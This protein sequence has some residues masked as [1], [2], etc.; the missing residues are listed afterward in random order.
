MDAEKIPDDVEDLDALPIT[1]AFSTG[2]QGAE[3]C[4][5]KEGE[6]VLA[7]GCAARSA[8]SRG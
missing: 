7:L 4:D 5:L 6:T 2:Y 8:C 3:M 1:D